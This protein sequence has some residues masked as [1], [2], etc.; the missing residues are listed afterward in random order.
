AHQ[1]AEVIT[2]DGRSETYRYDEAA[3]L[4]Y[5]PHHRRV[6]V[7]LGNRLLTANGDD[8]TYDHRNNLAAWESEG[9]TLRFHHD[10]LDQ[11]RRIDGL[12][13]A[14]TADY[15]PLGRRI[16]KAYGAEVTEYFWDTDRLVAELLP[17]GRL[18]V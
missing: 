3:N 14:W 10:A 2:P 6:A 4:I 16:R 18:R 9:R 7:G 17:D 13:H 8:F 1:L 11:L 15:D 12:E 5:A